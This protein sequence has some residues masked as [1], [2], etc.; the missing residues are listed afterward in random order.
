MSSAAGPRAELAEA[1]RLIGWA[2]QPARSPARNAEYRELVGRYLDDETFAG[3]CDAVAGGLGLTLSVDRESGVIA[4]AEP[5]SALAMSMAEFAKRTSQQHRRALLGLVLLGV[6]RVAFPDES[7]L[8][9]PHR[10]VRVSVAAVVE[11]L[12]RLVERLAQNS[13]D[14]TA[15]GRDLFELWR[16]WDDLKT[17][18]HNARRESANERIGLVRKVCRYLDDEGHLQELSDDDGG[19]YRVLPRFRHAVRSLVEDSDL[20]A[21]FLHATAEQAGHADHNEQV[22]HAEHA[23]QVEQAGSDGAHDEHRART[24]RTDAAPGTEGEP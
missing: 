19:T 4:V 8:D 14:R 10:V 3:T 17:T 24:G 2:A 16:S 13:P 20:Y 18:R 12:N 6:A 23:E 22:G 15:G 5:G 9:D 21:Q 7:Q 11:Y 1:G